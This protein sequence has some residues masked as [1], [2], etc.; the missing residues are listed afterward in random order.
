MTWV[1]ETLEVLEFYYPFADNLN[2]LLQSLIERKEKK[3]S[4]PAQLQATTTQWDLHEDREVQPLLKWI[5]DTLLIEFLD[6]VPRPTRNTYFK[7]VECWGIHYQ[8]GDFI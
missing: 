8:T 6:H 3:E 2:P 5:N 7:L 1:R 4:N